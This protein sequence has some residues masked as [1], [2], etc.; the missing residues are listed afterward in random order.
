MSFVGLDK[1]KQDLLNTTSIGQ[2]RQ[3]S[4]LPS[5]QNLNKEFIIIPTVNKKPSKQITPVYFT[6]NRPF[7][8][9]RNFGNLIKI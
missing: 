8:K 6:F 9:S 4:R 5:L 2:F 3:T 7:Y 1:L